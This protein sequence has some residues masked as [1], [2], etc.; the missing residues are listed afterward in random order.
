MT[1][2]IGILSLCVIGGMLVGAAFAQE[3]ATPNPSTATTGKANAQEQT[4]IADD[5][6]V[7]KV[8]DVKV[9]KAQFDALFAIYEAGL[10]PTDAERKKFAEQYASALM[11]S[12]QALEHHLDSSPE[13]VRQ[14]ALD[15]TQILSNAEYQR[16]DEQTKPSEEE[17]AGYYNSHQPDFDLVT[18]HRIFVWK[19]RPGGNVTGLSDKEA[20]AKAEEIRRSLVSGGDPKK[21]TTDTNTTL[22]TDPITLPRDKVPAYLEK[23]AFESKV[24]EWAPI[25]DTPDGVVVVRVDKRWRQSLK[26]ATPYIEKKVHNQK[27]NAVLEELKKGAGV[28]MNE[29]Y[30]PKA[31][32]S[33]EQ[34]ESSEGLQAKE[35]P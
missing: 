32:D 4:A 20:V 23:V 6:V 24:G 18:L 25:V 1:R 17:I 10:A 21:L 14:L 15:R 16:L 22:N 12:H 2:Y 3:S 30:I 33:A 9:T 8:G 29:A 19:K 31:S 28:W 11:L 13:V 5:A 26:E 35:K 34:K 27:L 7:L